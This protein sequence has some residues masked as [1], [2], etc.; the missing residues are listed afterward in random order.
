MTEP[1]KPRAAHTLWAVLNQRCPNCRD[2][3]IYARGMTMHT[4]CPSCNVLFEREPGYFMGS[5]YVSYA[6]AS[7]FILLGLIVG[8]QLMPNLDLGWVALMSGMVFVPC[9]PMVTRYARVI[10]MYFDHWSWP[11]RPSESEDAPPPQP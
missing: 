9:V 7:V 5:L 6:L 10:W 4:R 11:I 8:H 2:G 1:A 3:K